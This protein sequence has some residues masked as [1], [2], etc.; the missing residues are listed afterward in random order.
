MSA[1]QQFDRFVHAHARKI[2][3]GPTD[4]KHEGWGCL[5][6]PPT[7]RK[8]ARA[9]FSPP[10]ATLPA[11]ITANTYITTIKSM[12]AITAKH[13]QVIDLHRFFL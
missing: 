4:L 5:C 2:F 11:T 3:D 7:C 1:Q 10:L 9:N 6:P 12:T 8:H 13:R